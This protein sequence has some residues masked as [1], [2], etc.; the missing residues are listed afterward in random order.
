MFDI[1]ICG[2]RIIDGSGSPWYR[3]DVGILGDRI[4]AIGKLEQAEARCVIEAKGRVVC[5]GFID[6]HT[7]SDIMPLTNPKHE[8][9]IRQGVTTDLIGL[10]GLS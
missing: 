3:G 4:A 1:I 2:G 6:M 7:H 5:P 8:P 10:D 9:K